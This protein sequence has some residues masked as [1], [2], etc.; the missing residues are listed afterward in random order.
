MFEKYFKSFKILFKLQ[1]RLTQQIIWHIFK[2]KDHT[3]EFNIKI[4][5]KIFG[6]LSAK[7]FKENG[8]Y[9]KFLSEKNTLLEFIESHLRVVDINFNDDIKRFLNIDYLKEQDWFRQIKIKQEKGEPYYMI[10]N[11]DELKKNLKKEELTLTEESKEKPIIKPIL[12]HF[13]NIGVNEKYINHWVWLRSF[14]GKNSDHF[15][16]F[17]NLILKSH[18]NS[19][20]GSNYNETFSKVKVLKIEKY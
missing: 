1:N 12:R 4:Y 10:Q 6:K 8:I 17:H 3:D 7:K 13:K 16:S 2:M 5:T 9:P 15:L 14:F 11:D 20:N 18:F 19:D